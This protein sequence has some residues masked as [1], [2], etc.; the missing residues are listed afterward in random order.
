MTDLIE[1]FVAYAKTLSGYEK[2]EAQVFCDRLFQAFGHQG[3]K[4]AGATLEYKVKKQVSANKKKTL[5]PDLVWPKRLLLEMKSRGENLQHHYKQA[6]KYWQITVPH[7]PRY[8]VLCNFDE[9][10]IYDF[11]LQIEEPVDK[12]SLEDL[13]VRY[14]AFTFL[15]PIAKEP[16]FKNNLVTVT[17]TAARQVASVFHSLVNRGLDRTE[18]QTFVLQC[19][20]TMFAEDIKL[21]P[22]G[23]FTELLALCRKGESSTYDSLGALFLQMNSSKQAR[24][25]RLKKVPYFNG[26]IFKTINPVELNDYELDMLWIAATENWAKVQPAIFGSIFQGSMDEASRH[27]A[28]A[29]YTSEADI[30]KIIQPTIVQPWQELIESSKTLPDFQ[31]LWKRL[32]SFKILDPACGSGNFLYVAYRELVRIETAILK[33]ATETL[34]PEEAKTLGTMSLIST[35][36]F[37]GIDNSPFAVDLAKVTLMLGKKLALDEMAEIR[38]MENP[39]LPAMMD[40]ALPL[41][42]LD[43]NFLCEDALFVQWPKADAIIGNPPYQSKNKMQKEFG[44]QYMHRLRAAFP[45]V[46]GRADYCVYWFKKAHDHLPLGGRAGLVGTNTIRQNYS[47][48]GGLDYIISHMGTI[49]DAVA[50]QPWSG[51]A[52]VHVSIV[53]WV[54]GPQKGIKRITTYIGDPPRG[55]WQIDEVPVINSSL[56][57]QIDVSSATVLKVNADSN[58]CLQGQTH[59]HEGF[60]L[61]REPAE[62]YLRHDSAYQDILFPY[63]IA[64][65]M[66]GTKDSLPRRYVIDFGEKDILN[67]G[68]YKIIFERIN[69]LV[70]PDRKKA[71]DEEKKRNEPVLNANPDA[72]VNHHHA[73]FLKRWWQLSYRRGA[74]IDEMSKRPCYIACGRVTRRPVFEM[75]ST[76]IHPNDSMQVFLLSDDYSFGILQSDIHWQ[77]FVARCSTL[78]GDYRYTSDTVF[79]SF[80]WPQQPTQKAVQ[81]VA[82]AAVDLRKLRRSL[83][84][85]NQTTLR[86]LYRTMDLPGEHPVKDAH[87]KLNEAVREAYGMTKEDDPLPFL[88]SLGHSLS[89]TE[90]SGGCVMGP[91]LPSES[92]AIPK[93]TEYFISFK[94]QD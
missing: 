55:I 60:I 41:E 86:D 19:V 12:I 77:W 39:D 5:F 72:K 88:L 73:N 28:G 90:S 11:D 32:L 69:K 65:D 67:A 48:I 74:L 84:A 25:G 68:H 53:N 87:A 43:P 27:T 59:G 50:T 29:H 20:V 26:G 89:A 82:I 93:S 14:S 70:L 80:P 76:K 56:S 79:D 42:N 33:R 85:D 49:T 58:I 8:V 37:H 1:N 94:A 40:Q 9:F 24:A 54:K 2:G 47:R 45:D 17:K 75:Y 62:R 21:L 13:P 38:K 30:Q 91:G 7:R 64:D 4:E 6:F 44:V 63:L 10:W 78:K 22:D 71:A 15:L 66:L 92:N 36:Q 34:G 35:N 57:P 51:D 83:M 46:P 16:I 81:R 52:V 3:Y 61:E 31:M 23:L 18:A